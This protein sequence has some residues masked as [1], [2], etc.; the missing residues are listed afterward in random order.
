MR[1]IQIT[2][3]H[4]SGDHPQRSIDLEN[5]IQAVNSIVPPPDLVVHTGDITHNGSSEE[6]RAAKALLDTLSAPYVVLAGN[7]DSRAELMDEFSD[8]VFVQADD[9][10]VQYS[11]EDYPVRL[12]AIDTVSSAS[13]GALCAERLQHIDH[14]LATDTGKPVVVFMHHNPFEATEIPDPFQFEDWTDVEKLLEIFSRY[15]RIH[16]IYCGH[17]HRNVEAKVG[18]VPIIALACTACDLRKGKLNK[19]DAARPMFNVIDLPA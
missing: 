17:I 19:E 18:E 4:I 6:Y 7:R 12:I 11:V 8:H 9:K 14:M 10:F 3:S 15:S 13:K 5:C 16:G 1:I 2:D